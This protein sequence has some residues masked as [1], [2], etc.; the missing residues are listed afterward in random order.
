M[1]TV[2]I[3]VSGGRTS[4]YMA[5]WMIHN[6]ESVAEHIGCN[7]DELVYL[8]NF[9][10]TGMEHE[11][12]LRFM[13]DVDR[14]FGL[15]ANW[16]EAV[17]HHGQR[18]SSTHRLVNYETAARNDQWWQLDHPFHAY[19]RK[20]GI[21]NV[22]FKSC[23]REL[24]LNPM[25]SYI[26]SLGLKKDEYYTAIGIRDDETRRV[27][28]TADVQNI[29]YPLV[30]LNP[31]DKQ[32]VL[33][34]WSQYDWDLKIPEW[35]GNCITCYKKSFKKLSKVYEETPIAFE[36]NKY[37]ENEY[38]FVGPEFGKHGSTRERAFFRLNIKTVNLITMFKNNPDNIDSYINVM[39]DAGCSE[40]CEMYD[41]V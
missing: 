16:V 13:N 36:F 27:S 38:P 35:Q 2:V 8:F 5:W 32:D 34:F 6:K 3:S 25:N 20:Y 31:V 33:E 10:N 15:N 14:H 7:V 17:V 30:D 29:I 21:P 24:K 23:T 37:M 1:V 9:A 40:S 39:K 28:A 11:D 12:T 41:M 18:K 19:I 22:K 26:K 4:A